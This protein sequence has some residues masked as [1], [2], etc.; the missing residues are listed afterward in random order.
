[1]ASVVDEAIIAINKTFKSWPFKVEK[2]GL[3]GWITLMN[4]VSNECTDLYYETSLSMVDF[5]RKILTKVITIFPQFVFINNTL[6][7]I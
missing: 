5:T 1:M 2:G 6:E 4:K 3:N 7:D